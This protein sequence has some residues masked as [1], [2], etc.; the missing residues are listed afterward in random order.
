MRSGGRA[1]FKM[2]RRRSTRAALL[3][4]RCIFE[5]VISSA[6]ADEKY[7]FARGSPQVAVDPMAVGK[8]STILISSVYSVLDPRLTAP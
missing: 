4:S 7:L 8:A 5:S 6:G 2:G 1:G 3:S